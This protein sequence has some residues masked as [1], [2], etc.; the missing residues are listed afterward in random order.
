MRPFIRKNVFQAAPLQVT[1]QSIAVEQKLQAVIVNSAYANA[2]TGE[3]GL[4]DAYEMRKLCAEA[5]GLPEHLVAV[6]STGVIGECL[7]ME[8]IRASIPKLKPT[9][10]L[11]GAVD[12]QTAILTTDLVM[13]KRVMKRL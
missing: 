5:F 10:Q 2:C 12:F 6:A 7:P 9:A 8:N 4:K 3:Q 11:D 1:K 13:K